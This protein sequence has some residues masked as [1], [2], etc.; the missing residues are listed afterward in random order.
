[1]NFGIQP[2]QRAIMRNRI[3]FGNLLAVLIT[4]MLAF[5]L[6]KKDTQG[7][8]VDSVSSRL[9][10]E[11][12]T[13][14]RSLK[15]SAWELVDNTRTQASLRAGQDVFAALDENSRRKRAYDFSESVSRWLSDSA[16]GRGTPEIVLVINDQGEVIAR[17]ANINSMLGVQL[18]G[19]AF[20]K[21]A[22]AG[23]STYDVWENKVDNKTLLVGIAPIRND[24][25]A[26][27]GALV[28]GYDFSNA[29]A[30]SEAKRLGRD[31]VLYTHKGLYSA[32]NMASA[33]KTDLSGSVFG[34]DKAEA[35]KALRGKT[36]QSFKRDLAGS[37][38]EGAFSYV[39]GTDASPLGA[40][41]LANISK[42]QTK[43][44]APWYVLGMTVL[45][46]LVVGGYNFFLSKQLQDPLAEMEEG[47]LSVI[48][49]NTETRLQIES[50]DYGGL[51][52]RINQLINMLTGV[53]EGGSSTGPAKAAAWKEVETDV[54]D[55]AL[56]S[57]LS[58]ESEDNYYERLF[59]EYVSA[60]TKLGENVTSI[61]KDKFVQRLV[62][63]EK[64]LIAKHQCKMVRFQVE[65][66]GTMVNLKPI[67]IR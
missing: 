1:M 2:A 33:L 19:L 54:A 52:Y 30:D 26:V 61:T 38:Y 21:S 6:V 25:G 7:V 28:V 32:S 65:V 9:S 34:T 31:V 56:A 15:L 41:V 14:T 17:N 49:G 36:S 13:I 66:Q 29:L 22:V 45:A 24:A 8:L 5:F 53:S 59:Q 11:V 23:S 67:V 27:L 64:S 42:E 3:L 47:I 62:A 46:L 44:N 40:L 60:K 12:E 18:G 16:R 51:V 35:E 4:G 20:V 58:S 55:P 48:N 37:S 10:G 57:T 43:S 63:N 39:M 50:E